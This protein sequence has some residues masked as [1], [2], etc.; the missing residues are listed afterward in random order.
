MAETATVA[1]GQPG[2]A[3]LGSSDPAAAR[4]FYAGVFGWKA[5][6]SDDP[7]AGGYGMFMLDGKEVAGTGP[8]MNEQQPVAWTVYVLVDDADAT[9]A[10]VKAAGG[11]VFAEPFDVMDAGRMAI[12]ADPSGG[13]LGIWQPGT[14]RGFEV[15]GTGGSFCWAELNSKDIAKDSAFYA[16]VFGWDPKVMPTPG[17]EYTQFE[18]NGEAIAGGMAMP[19]EMPSGTPSHWLVYFATAD[20]DATVAKLTSLGGG[21]HHPPEDIPEVGRFAVVHDP[22][23]G[24]FGLLQPIS[25]AAAS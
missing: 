25:L 21:V 18:H 2:W 8:L 15:K 6:V 17:M 16:S 1:I 3:D 10:K 23:G 20:V 5:E 13:V 14:H 22:Q 11:T 12:V 9:A 24:V 4:A 7:Q 19:I